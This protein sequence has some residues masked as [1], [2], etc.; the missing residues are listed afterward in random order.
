MS[1]QKNRINTIVAI[2][3]SNPNLSTGNLNKV[4]AELHQVI[5]VHSILP[6]R[7]RNLMKILHSTRALD[8]TLS[9]FLSFHQIKN[10]A[11]S[12]G[13]YLVQLRNHNSQNLGNLSASERDKYQASIAKLRN[14]H[15]H[16][17]D[18]YPANEREVNELIAEMQT[19][20]ARIATL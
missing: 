3:N 19:L 8:S 2:L 1:D 20:I 4:K 16:T 15:L 12:I 14:T 6:T 10:R 13:Q 18:S 11:S 7:R 5:D 17:A 9:S